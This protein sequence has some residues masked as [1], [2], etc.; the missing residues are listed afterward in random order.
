MEEI[1][2]LLP[3]NILERGLLEDY[4]NESLQQGKYLTKIQ[5]VA[6]GINGQSIEIEEFYEGD[7]EASFELVST[8][9]IY[10]YEVLFFQP[11]D[12]V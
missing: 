9:M 1:K 10:S 6:Q 4:L 5:P 7:Y 12:G 3:F 2:V 8:E 11:N